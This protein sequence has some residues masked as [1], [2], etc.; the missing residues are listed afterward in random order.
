MCAVIRKGGTFY[1]LKLC[2]PKP[3]THVVFDA[4]EGIGCSEGKWIVQ[5]TG[6]ETAFIKNLKHD[7]AYLGIDGEIVPGQAN[8]IVAVSECQEWRLQQSAEPYS[9][10]LIP[11]IPNGDGLT[12]DL[13]VLQS[14]EDQVALVPLKEDD[15]EQAWILHFIE[16]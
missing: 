11:T 13:T 7:K 12:M 9:F 2:N 6:H 8:R 3:G 1:R 16:Q 15:A 4:P 10:F 14:H 5:R